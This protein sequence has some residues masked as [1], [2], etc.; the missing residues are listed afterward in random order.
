[1]YSRL[2]CP[3]VLLAGLLIVVPPAFGQRPTP[4]EEM[5]RANKSPA[6][7]VGQLRMATILG[8]KTLT[9]LQEAAPDDSVPLDEGLIQSARDTYFLIRGA[10]AGLHLAREAK[11]FR[12]PILEYKIARITQAWNLS[13]TPVDYA[14][15]SLPRQEYL[16]R[17]IADLGQ[18]LMIVEQVLTLMYES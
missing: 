1:M 11:K 10:R 13:R 6:K 17:A 16:R 12:D 15:S 2:R 8:R 14:R 9:G 7:I 18:A 5:S 3:I 4:A